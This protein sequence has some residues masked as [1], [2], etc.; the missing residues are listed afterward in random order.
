M[1]PFGCWNSPS[2]YGSSYR[3]WKSP[4]SYGS[5]S[6]CWR[7]LSIF[8]ISSSCCRSPSSNLRSPDLRDSIQLLKKSQVKNA[9]ATGILPTETV[10]VKDPRFLSPKTATGELLYPSFWYSSFLSMQSSPP[11]PS[12]LLLYGIILRI[13]SSAGFHT[14]SS[15]LYK[16]C[17]GSTNVFCR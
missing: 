16:L 12:L 4:S 13:T 3:C 17:L 1:S 8:V 11:P 9:I 2:S 14:A 10:N 6:S 15:L 5:L 7:S